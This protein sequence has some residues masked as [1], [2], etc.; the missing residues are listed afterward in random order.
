MYQVF[1]ILRSF[2][3]LSETRQ[4][5][6]KTHHRRVCL[7]RISAN[8]N[9]KCFLSTLVTANQKTNYEEE[10]KEFFSLK[11]IYAHRSFTAVTRVDVCVH[12]NP[13]FISFCE[14]EA[15]HHLLA[16]IIVIALSTGGHSCL[17]FIFKLA[18]G[19]IF[20]GEIAV[21]IVWWRWTM[22]E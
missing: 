1:Y 21:Y 15:V 3:S 22:M 14:K 13:V 6:K 2:K 9:C 18:G 12:R 11:W 20:K 7:P 5:V 10:D 17:G 19:M 16:P 4:Y 8:K